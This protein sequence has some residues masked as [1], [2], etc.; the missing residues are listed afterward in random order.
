MA[1]LV[2]QL[3]RDSPT[4]ELLRQ[5]LQVN[6]RDPL[7]DLVTWSAVDGTYR[8]VGGEVADVTALASGRSAE[9]VTGW[10]GEPLAV[11]LA[12][13]SSARDRSLMLT[14][15]V[16]IRLTLDNA[17]LSRRLLTSDYE[18]RQQ[19]ASDLHD[20]VQNKLC[21]LL[22]ALSTARQSAD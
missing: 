6:L 8:T 12:D 7:L 18:A 10:S 22:V 20:G 21:G 1:D 9:L 2:P 19:L 15:A 11:L 13:P 16:L 5:V 4:A 17:Q 14:A 3:D